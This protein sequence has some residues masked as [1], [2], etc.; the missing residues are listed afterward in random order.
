MRIVLLAIAIAS[1][2]SFCTKESNTGNSYNGL[3]EL[4]VTDNGSTGYKEYPA[5]NGYKLLIANDSIY[6][7]A[8]NELN[9]RQAFQLVKDTLTGYG[10]KRVADKL[11]LDPEGP[12]GIFFELEN[13]TLTTYFG[14]PAADGGSSRYVRVN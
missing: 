12:S 13:N 4:R 1:T 14:I 11:P 10:E 8:N 3:W 5:G 6:T 7:Y 9:H 2:F